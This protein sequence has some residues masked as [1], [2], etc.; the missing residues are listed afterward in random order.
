MANWRLQDFEIFRKVSQAISRTPQNVSCINSN[1]LLMTVFKNFQC[2]CKNRGY[3]PTMYIMSLA[4][5]ALLSFPRVFSTMFNNS[6]I[7]Y[8]RKIFSSFSVCPPLMD[9]IA[10]QMVLSLAQV[11]LLDPTCSFNRSLSICTVSRE[12]M[13]VKY[14]NVS[15]IELYRMISSVSGVNSGCNCPFSSSKI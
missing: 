5:T 10:Q 13:C 14:S 4:I 15:L 12:S 1:N 2:D 8:T 6:R 7:T 3:C 11:H 9:P